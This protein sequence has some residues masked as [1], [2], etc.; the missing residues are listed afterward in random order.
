[1]TRLKDADAG[2]LACSAFR[3][4]SK[5]EG[6]YSLL[7]PQFCLCPLS[8]SPV[9]KNASRIIAASRSDRMSGGNDFVDS[10]TQSQSS[11]SISPFD[12]ASAS[13]EERIPLQSSPPQPCRTAQTASRHLTAPLRSTTFSI[14]SATSQAPISTP[15]TTSSNQ[16]E[17]S[18]ATNP[19][20]LTKHSKK[21]PHSWWWWWWE[22]GGAAL[23]MLSMYLIFLVLA[24]VNNKPLEN[25]RVPIQPN[26]LI[27]ACSRENCND[28]PYHWMSLAA[29]VGAALL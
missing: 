9:S 2:L 20:L 13:R 25:W 1:M 8:L 6:I 28:G 4:F 10:L 11:W 12:S 16:K 5:R 17:H 14:S 24:D 3:W 18:S 21:P 23:S 29:Q 15:F 27:A 7:Y 22:I 26:S 19:S